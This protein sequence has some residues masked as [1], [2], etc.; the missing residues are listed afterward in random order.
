MIMKEIAKRPKLIDDLRN[1]WIHGNLKMK[2]IDQRSNTEIMAKS[3]VD[4]VQTLMF[5][6]DQQRKSAKER[7]T[8]FYVLS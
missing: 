6:N 7:N 2:S 4:E 8:I 5:K 3:F 1:K